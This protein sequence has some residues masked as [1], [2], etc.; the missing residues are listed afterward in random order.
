MK[1]WL[2]LLCF[3]GLLFWKPFTASDVARLKP[4]EVIRVSTFAGGILVETDTGD[5]GIGKDINKAMADL[6]LTTDGDVFLETVD[7]LLISPMAVSL[8]PEL[9]AIL[10]PGCNVCVEMGQVELESVS[11]YLNMHEPGITLQDHRAGETAL[12][13]LYVLDGRMYLG[14]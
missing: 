10:R 1:K 13:V 9:G 8:L 11:A 5:T 12:P 4:V 14:K 6:K 2:L 7:S 3:C